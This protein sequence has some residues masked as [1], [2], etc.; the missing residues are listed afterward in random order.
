MSESVPGFRTFIIY[1]EDSMVDN[2]Y[3]IKDPVRNQQATISQTSLFNSI[4]DQFMHKLPVENSIEITGNTD[5]A[6]ILRDYVDSWVSERE[7]QMK[8]GTW[9]GA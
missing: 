6:I 4:K 8:A 9:K 1:I 5:A 7:I 3:L 2:E